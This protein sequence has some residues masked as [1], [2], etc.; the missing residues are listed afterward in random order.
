[1]VPPLAV[2]AA[3]AAAAAAAASASGAAGAPL[4]SD[5]AAGAAGGGEE[6]K[7]KQRFWQATRRSAAA[8]NAWTSAGGTAPPTTMVSPTLRLWSML[9]TRP[10]GAT[11][12]AVAAT[13][14]VATVCVPSWRQNVVVAGMGAV[15]LGR[16]FYTS[17]RIMIDFKLLDW[18]YDKDHEDYRRLHSELLSTSAHR[19]LDLCKANGGVFIKLAQHISAF[20]SAPR[21]IVDV[22]SVLQDKAPFRSYETVE[23]L[24]LKDTGKVSSRKAGL[25][26]KLGHNRGHTSCSSRSSRRPLPRHRS[27]KS[28]AQRQRM[29]RSSR[30]RCSTRTSASSTRSTCGASRRWPP[31]LRAGLTPLT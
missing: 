6:V 2:G 4:A 10:M 12:L 13:G 25:F 28:T 19:M 16:V 23:R 20:G 5:V 18:R 22:L 29:D 1:M 21:E 11:V 26:P 30:S 15:R 31:L 27:P 8:Y 14:A 24:F 7:N 3:A 17:A 9:R